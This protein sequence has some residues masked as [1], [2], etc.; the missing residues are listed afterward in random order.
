MIYKKMAL[1][2]VN[3]F[4]E[5]I[6]Q[7]IQDLIPPDPEPLVDWET[8]YGA[9]RIYQTKHYITHGGGPEGGYVYFYRE[10][11][12]GWYKWERDWFRPPTYTKLETGVVAMIIMEDGAE[13]I[14]VLPDNWEELMQF[15]EDWT[16]IIGDD[17]TMQNRDTWNE[18]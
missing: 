15:D 17:E 13:R 5:N 2:F 3:I 1:A 16:V 8:L 10:R 12:A 14:G 4:D 6:V 11:E 9:E 18:D 7:N